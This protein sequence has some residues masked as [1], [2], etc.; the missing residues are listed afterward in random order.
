MAHMCIFLNKLQLCLAVFLMFIKI[1]QIADVINSLHLVQNYK[2][3]LSIYELHEQDKC[4]HNTSLH[5][6]IA[7][8]QITV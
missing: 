3:L 7:H 1:S 8:F 4:P 5:T 2:S 6:R